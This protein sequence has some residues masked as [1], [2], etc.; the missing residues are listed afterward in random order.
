MTLTGSRVL[1]TGATGMVGLP[2]ALA[3]TVDNDVVAAA[4]F[5]DAAARAR[6]E[7]AG[8]RCVEIDLAGA[9]SGAALAG[10]PDVDHV[11]HFAVVKSN[12]WERD[13]DGNAGPVAAL[14]ERYAGA[15]A[16]LHCSTTGLYQP[17]GH[18]RFAE[19]DPLGD[20]HRVLPFLSTYSISKIA[21]ETMAR[22]A[23]RRWQLPTVIA[24][25]NVPYGDT[26]GWPSVHLEMMLQD[27][28][29]G[30]SRDAP[31]TYNPIHVDD[32]VATLPALLAA[33]SVP[34]TTVNWGGD[35]EVS[36]EDWCTEIGALVGRQARLVPADMALPS[37]ALD[38]TRMH[39][40][41][42]H[43]TV[44]W[45]EGMRRMVAAL[46]PELPVGS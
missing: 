23:A 26:G 36:V 19:G 27:M 24:R 7:E 22:W 42:G 14:V 15:T 40:L 31:S 10:L 25:L 46:H 2:V 5:R 1:I 32:I 12:R 9:E 4:R 41:V 13:L 21:A 45:R 39:E 33:A 8:V 11:L 16:L 30:V 17:D 44:A 18:H 6:L 29:I 20:N 35:E 37:V 28:E 3:L 38:L 43:T 34:A